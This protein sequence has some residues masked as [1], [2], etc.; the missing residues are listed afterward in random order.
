[1]VE[2]G[3]RRGN[4]IRVGVGI[5]MIIIGTVVLFSMILGNFT[6]N[7]PFA[8]LA[9]ISLVLGSLLI[10]TSVSGRAV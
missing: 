9:L 7:L 4:R 3:E 6:V 2:T 5:L 10:G 8:A 1:M